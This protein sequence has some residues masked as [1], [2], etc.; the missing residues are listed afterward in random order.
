MIFLIISIH[1]TAKQVTLT[2]ADLAG[3]YEFH[4]RLGGDEIMLN[5]DGT[6][7]RESRACT[8]GTIAYGKYTISNNV[9]HFTIVKYFYRRNGDTKL[10]DL[11]DAKQRKDV[12]R[13]DSADPDRQFSLLLVRWS[14]RL[15]LMST[16]ETDEFAEAINL[17]VEPREESGTYD[18]YGTFYLRKGDESK[19]VSGKPELPE[20]SRA[21]L[22]KEPVTATIID[23]EQGSATG[24]M[25]ATIDKGTSDG[26][27]AGMSL[28]LGDKAKFDMTRFQIISLSEQ[29]AKVYISDHLQVGDKLSTQC[30]ACQ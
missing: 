2:P 5:S 15:Y 17:G 29:S 21:L 11:F 10:V 6:F 12:F 16:G 27:R 26:L 25:V 7:S 4:F 18:D 22:L 23:I 28:F 3:T 9:L 24:K 13:E 8:D 30:R 14:S 19:G 20:K 1:A